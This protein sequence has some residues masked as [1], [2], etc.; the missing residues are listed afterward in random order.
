MAWSNGIFHVFTDLRNNYIYLTYLS[1]LIYVFTAPR[2]E[3]LKVV[4]LSHD[5]LVPTS[6]GSFRTKVSW[7]K[8]LFN[9]SAVSHYSYKITNSTQK[10]VGKMRRRAIDFDAVFTTVSDILLQFFAESFTV[11]MCLS[12][13][14]QLCSNN[15]S[16]FLPSA[17]SV[18]HLSG[19]LREQKYTSITSSVWERAVRTDYVVFD[20]ELNE[21]IVM[22]INSLIHTIYFRCRKTRTSQ[23]TESSW[24]KKSNSRLVNVS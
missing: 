4:G 11:Y 14:C 5:E 10:S 13:T 24:V 22:L 2:E 1:Q 21:M 12:I 7:Q 6:D 9:H 16:L 3:L 20:T 23:L 18:N 15:G 8:P 17:A 19:P